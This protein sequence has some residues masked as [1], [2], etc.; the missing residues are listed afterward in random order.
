MKR[1]SFLKA[2]SVF[3]LPMMLGGVNIGVM[4]NSKLSSLLQEENDRVFVLIQ[5]NGGN[6]GL[7]MV[8][9]VDQYADLFSLRSNIILPEN[10]ILKLTDETGLHPAMAGMKSLYDEKVLTIIQGVGY[11]NQNRS[12]FRSTDIWDS[13]SIAQEVLTS[14]WIGRY[15]D[16]QHF[17][18][19]EGY[20]NTE[21]PHPIAIT[22][23]PSVS[24]TCQGISSN[25]SLAINDPTSLI[26]IPGTTGGT[27]PDLPYGDE[28]NFLRQVVQQTNVYAEVLSQV[29]EKGTN[30][31][32]LYPETGQN[33]LADQLKI[34]TQLISGGLKTKIYVVNINGFDTHAN[35]VSQGDVS[36]GGHAQLL[37]NLSEA[38]LAFMD[39]LRNQQLDHRVIGATRSEFG[40]QIASNGSLG[41]DHGDAAPL[42]V[43][44]SCVNP[45]IIGGNPQIAENVGPQ[46]G[47]P[48]Q[49]D[50]KN[51]FGSILIDW[52]GLSE[53][54]TVPL[55]SHDFEYLP[56]VTACNTTTAAGPISD[57]QIFQFKPYPNPFFEK[58]NIS[59]NSPGAQIKLSL[60][61]SM[62]Q[63]IH[64][65]ENKYFPHGSYQLSHQV[66]ELLPGQYFYQIRSERFSQAI[67]MIHF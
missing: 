44:G 52:F 21:N 4:A 35:Q 11:E 60:T 58:I 40:R 46:S 13:G 18:Y 42:I 43:F 27:L 15:L 34:V 29:A 3:S 55:F 49:I 20:P 48:V 25:F 10:Q 65:I 1:R 2:G 66:P 38:I 9:P 36:T 57:F 59:F 28:L 17:G 24:E 19:P 50:F 16:T 63:E 32:S 33:R 67:P 7:N 45:G 5:Q 22:L 6:D 23:G 37:S 54:E 31:S 51:I 14:G 26:T 8:I 30:A 39:D 41:T 47:V 12:H 62:G 53:A 61:N 64:K 56:I